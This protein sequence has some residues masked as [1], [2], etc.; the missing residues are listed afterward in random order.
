MELEMSTTQ[1]LTIDQLIGRYS[2]YTCTYAVAFWTSTKLISV[3]D[4][5]DE[6]VGDFTEDQFREWMHKHYPQDHP[7]GVG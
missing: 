1:E 5:E 4:D 6:H 2:D 7:N 3:Y